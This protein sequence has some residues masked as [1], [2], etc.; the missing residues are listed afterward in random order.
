MPVEQPWFEPAKDK[1]PY[2][3]W[4]VDDDRLLEKPDCTMPPIAG[5]VEQVVHTA[6]ELAHV[7]DENEPAGQV[8]VHADVVNPVV[9]PY[10]PGGQQVHAGDVAPPVEYVPTEQSPV[11]AVV[12]RPLV[13]P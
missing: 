2:V 11:Q 13:A 5:A 3:P 12:V 9:A 6:V 10:V 8:P 4:V 7:A 1:T